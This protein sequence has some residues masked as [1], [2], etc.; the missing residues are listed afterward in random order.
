VFVIVDGHPADRSVKVQQCVAGTKSRLQ[1]SFLPPYSPGQNPGE[2][3][4]RK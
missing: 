3:A 4:G 1:S 2:Q